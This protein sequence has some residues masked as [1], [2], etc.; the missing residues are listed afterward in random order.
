[1][2]SSLGLPVKPDKQLLTSMIQELIINLRTFIDLYQDLLIINKV[3]RQPGTEKMGRTE[4]R[5]KTMTLQLVIKTKEVLLR[6]VTF[7]FH[8]LII[9]REEILSGKDPRLR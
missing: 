5:M 3:V 2:Y 6:E 7:L 4:K 1:M 8:A 9:I